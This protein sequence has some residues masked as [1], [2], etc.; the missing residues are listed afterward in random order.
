[1][2]VLR[3]LLIV[4][5]VVVSCKDNTSTAQSTTET[6]VQTAVL[7]SVSISVLKQTS[8]D[9]ITLLDV[10]T[11]EEFQAGH[12]EN[13]INI[14]LFDENFVEKV[15]ALQKDD[16][17]IYCRSGARSMRASKALNAEGFTVTNL[18]GGYNLYIALQ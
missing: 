6:T 1:M 17:Y 7:N 2:N 5:L 18:E 16:L 3:T 13:A 10:R 4:A 14:N 12:V 9:S 8:T 15:K 11:P